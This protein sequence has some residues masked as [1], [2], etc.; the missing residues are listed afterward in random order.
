[1]QGV[2]HQGGEALLQAVGVGVG[3]GHL[4]AC[5]QAQAAGSL[6]GHALVQVEQHVVGQK[7]LAAQ[8]QAAGVVAGLV[9]QGAHERAHAL[10][11]LLDQLKGGGLGTATQQALAVAGDQGDRCAQLMVADWVSGDIEN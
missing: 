3:A 11:L 7:R 4:G 6:G 10:G 2:V 5:L 1:L 8:V 9:E